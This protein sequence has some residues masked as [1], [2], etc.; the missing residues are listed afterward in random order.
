MDQA[1]DGLADRI[2]LRELVEAYAAL[3]DAGD[4]EA[5]GALFA[6]DA[7]LS[8]HDGNGPAVGGYSG[9]P[10]I[11]QIPSKL[12]RHALTVHL[13]GTCRWLVEGDTA[14]GVVHGEAHHV[15]EPLAG[16]DQ[17]ARTDQI[18]TIRYDDRYRRG[19]DGAWR[20][21]H[22]AVHKLFTRTVEVRV[23]RADGL[24]G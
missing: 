22:R 24:G 2:A 12:S 6:D 23:G 9:R 19:A 7:S 3:A 14:T 8:M 15:S 13:V 21:E 11:A 20:F 4:L 18:M 1:H 17:G 16:A 10:D 5:F